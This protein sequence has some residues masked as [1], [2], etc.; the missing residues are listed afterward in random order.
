MKPGSGER[1][2]VSRA[3]QLDADKAQQYQTENNYSQAIVNYE[4]VC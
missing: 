3:A 2:A 4:M 1:C